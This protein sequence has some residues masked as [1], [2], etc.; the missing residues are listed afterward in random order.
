MFHVNE[1]GNTFWIFETKLSNV[2]KGVIEIESVGFKPFRLLNT[3]PKFPWR[4]STMQG[5]D[6]I[7]RR[8]LISWQKFD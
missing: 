7:K 4:I 6:C 5:I 3:P 1:D 8:K 2:S